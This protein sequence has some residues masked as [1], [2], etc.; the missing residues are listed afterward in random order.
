MQPAGSACKAIRPSGC[1]AA[2]AKPGGRRP[3]P[4][5]EH[6]A[7]MGRVLEAKSI[8]DFGNGIL[9]GDLVHLGFARLPAPHRERGYA[10]H[11]A[12]RRSMKEKMVIWA[13]FG[14]LR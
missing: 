13:A 4:G 7:E 3:E 11:D 9:G 6:P 8:G 12:S 2:P 5:F 14:A 10:G 1:P